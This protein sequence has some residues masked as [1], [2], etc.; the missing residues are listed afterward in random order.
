MSLSLRASP[1]RGNGRS[2]GFGLG[3]FVWQSSTPNCS[4]VGIFWEKLELGVGAVVRVL[5]N[6]VFRNREHLV[7]EPRP[8]TDA[9]LISSAR[10]ELRPVQDRGL[11]VEFLPDLEKMHLWNDSGCHAVI[12]V[13]RRSGS[14]NQ[15]LSGHSDVLVSPVTG[16]RVCS[17]ET[18]HHSGE[19]LISSSSGITWFDFVFPFDREVWT[20]NVEIGE[21]ALSEEEA[22]DIAASFRVRPL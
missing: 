19:L 1:E 17:F 21:H 8:V 6:R 15:Y 10:W 11:E 13:Y 5:F 14:Y 22:R 16:G 7:L 20:L 2:G 4:Q 12:G 18:P 9:L 3:G